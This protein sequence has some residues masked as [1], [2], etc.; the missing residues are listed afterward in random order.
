MSTCSLDAAPYPPIKLVHHGVCVFT[1]R[2]LL[3]AP[4]IILFWT[5]NNSVLGWKW[6]KGNEKIPDTTEF[7]S[8]LASWNQSMTLN[9]WLS[10]FDFASV[11]TASSISFVSISSVSNGFATL[12]ACAEVFFKALDVIFTAT[13]QLFGH[14]IF[15]NWRSRSIPSVCLFL[16]W[17]TRK[18]VSHYIHRRD[19]LY[20]PC[21]S[22]LLAL[23]SG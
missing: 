6:Q 12:V 4:K 1:T 22:P 20:K 14:S 9:P 7:S 13:Y 2:A 15:P 3:S 21:P 11:M 17:R 19:V 5:N 16:R 10:L 18:R 8:S 23:L